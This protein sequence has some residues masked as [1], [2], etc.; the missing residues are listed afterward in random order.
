[1]RLTLLYRGPL[2]SCN[3]DCG[4]CPFAK[5]QESP[6]ELLE[7]RRA[8]GR[9]VEWIA[10]HPEHRISV[11][12]VPWGEALVRSWY[13][14]ALTMLTGLEH[15]EKAAVQTNLSC[16]VEWLAA[17]GRGRIALWTTF[18]PSETA[19]GRFV[20][21]CRRL[22]ELGVRFSV[23]I[24]GL[25]EN[26]AEAEALR[27][28]LPSEVYVWVNAFKGVRGYYTDEERRRLHAVDPLF[29]L[30]ELDHPSRG[31]ACRT[32]SSV[33]LV[34]GDGTLRRCAFVHHRLGNL[35][36]AGF[37]RSLRERPCPNGACGCHVGYAHLEELGL[38]E[39]FG[40]GLLERVPEGFRW[41]G[42]RGR[43]AGEGQSAV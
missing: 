21:K 39:L 23:G 34:E 41:Q 8:L 28:E 15:V 30:N 27:R 11:L 9:F 6:E 35:Y 33:L 4:Y 10:A 43:G 26:L 12:F 1:M 17:C 37:E 22:L 40:E 24:V 42:A 32:G 13:R 16:G 25:R 14:E 19:R 36:E 2:S 20:G 3:Y 31:K 29:S 7:D 5:R 38:D 18:H